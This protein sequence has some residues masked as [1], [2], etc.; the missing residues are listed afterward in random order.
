[1][2][3]GGALFSICTDLLSVPVVKRC[4][5]VESCG[6]FHIE[7]SIDLFIV[8]F[9]CNLLSYTLLYRKTSMVSTNQT[10]NN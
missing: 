2:V 6:I 3:T 7:D 10:G 9:L 4:F 1:M 8:K 5:I